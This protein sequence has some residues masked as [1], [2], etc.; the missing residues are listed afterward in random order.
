MTMFKIAQPTRWLFVVVALVLTT[1]LMGTVSSGDDTDES[2]AIKLSAEDQRALRIG[3]EVLAVRKAIK[4]Y[5]SPD[6]AKAI[7]D[8]GTITANYVMVRGWL[9]EE[10]RTA[11]HMA[12]VRKG[13]AREESQKK[14]AFL[15]RAIRSIDLE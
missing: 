5:D 12:E 8:A 13:K 3:R 4:N 6:A 2:T 11:T 7:R 15:K 14:A 10:L 9:S 1:T